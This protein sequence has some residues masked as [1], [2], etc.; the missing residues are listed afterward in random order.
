MKFLSMLAVPCVLLILAGFCLFQPVAEA[1]AASPALPQE[2]PQA[3]AGA[4][5][6]IP[7]AGPDAIFPAVV[8]RV[9]SDPIL[10]RDLEV[11]VRRELA[12]IGNPEWQNL[13]EDYRGQ[14][15]L[16]ALNMLINTKLIYNEAIA[17]GM[18]A[19]DEDVQAELKRI[20]E[21]FD[22]DAEMN[23]ALAEQMLDRATLEQDLYKRL[24]AN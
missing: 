8:A 16:A 12:P 15:T 14:L 23:A 6:A 22:S 1:G 24:A 4:A 5:G 17:S 20:S 18:A 19:T 10:G 11:L 9:D 7:P 2:N 21:T 3:K 13:R